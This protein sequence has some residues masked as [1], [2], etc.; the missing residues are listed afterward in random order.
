MSLGYAIAP[1]TLITVLP[2]VWLMYSK[3]S[4][5]IEVFL[6]CVILSFSI[7]GPLIAAMSFV[8]NLAKIGTTVG[9]VEEILN[10]EEQQHLSLIHIF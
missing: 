1:T 6:T 8:D 9:S 4:L 10:A 7:V 2:V 5:S 3:G